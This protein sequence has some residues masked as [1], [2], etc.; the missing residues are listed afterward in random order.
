MAERRCALGARKPIAVQ[1]LVAKYDKAA[2][3]QSAQVFD[4]N[5]IMGWVSCCRPQQPP[6]GR[7]GAPRRLRLHNRHQ[8]LRPH[9]PMRTPQGPSSSSTFG[10]LYSQRAVPSPVFSTYLPLSASVTGELTVGGVNPARYTGAIT[11]AP[12][13][14]N[15]CTNAG[16]ASSCL[17]PNVPAGSYPFWMM[18][19]LNVYLQSGG[20][21]ATLLCANCTGVADSGTSSV[22]GPDAAIRQIQQG[23][24]AGLSAAACAA[25]LVFTLPGGG[26][27]VT[28]PLNR[29]SSEGRGACTPVVPKALFSSNSGVSVSLMWFWG[30]V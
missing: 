22:V 26:G 16:D 18:A 23:Y 28:V 13:S 11:Y 17:V 8:S 19:G 4:M 7:S 29:A 30:V 1:T 27:N 9:P 21:A 24:G 3:G 5:G 25:A 14:P 10:T 2:S 12:V 15:T 6:S 20:G